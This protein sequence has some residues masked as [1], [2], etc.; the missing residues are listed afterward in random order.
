VNCEIRLT[1]LAGALLFWGLVAHAQTISQEISKALASSPAAR[2]AFWGIY[3][4]DAET[5]R[6]I[7]RL[8]ADHYFVPASNAKLFTTALAL[9]R[10]GAEFRFQTRVTAPHRP[11]SSG[12]I[13]G[14]LRLIGGGDPNLSGRPIPYQMGAADG[15]PLQAVRELAGEVAAQGVRTVDGD[16][17]G[18]DTWY[19]WESYPSGWSLDDPAYDYGAPAS[20]LSINDNSQTV[21]I[22]AAP[23]PGEPAAISLKPAIEYYAIENRIR[24]VAAGGARSIHFT[25]LPG[26]R[27][28][29]LWGTIPIGGPGE[30]ISLAIEDP[31]EFAA[32]AFRQALQER[33]IS[34]LGAARARHR[35][36]GE[37]IEPESAGDVELARRNS[38]PL[39]EDLRLTD[40]VSQNLHAE[41]DLRAVARARKGSGSREDGLDELRGFLSEA[42]LNPLSTRFS[43]GSG[44]SRLNLVT[45]E[46][47][48]QLLRYMFRSPQRENWMSLLPIGGEDGTL[49]VRFSDSPGVRHVLA[50]TGSL[51]GVHALSGYVQ[52]PAG[53]W[54][55]FSILVNNVNG[56]AREVR[57]IIDRICTLILE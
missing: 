23:R 5:G 53:R 21:T 42:G 50:K 49:S 9:T 6:V 56:K 39:I 52:N 51:T 11:D 34:V 47:V 26:S 33:G 46:A 41:L 57:G 35:M 27:N 18:D 22:R 45:P 10:L 15:D 3:V 54:L 31:A 2:T 36:P 40:K 28:I 32:I 13:R 29:R 44:L 30:A 14:D 43:D 55:A 8:N 4:A 16:I 7:Y 17:V 24:T 12:S 19:T 38:A 20:A 37:E 25:R 1:R 48:V